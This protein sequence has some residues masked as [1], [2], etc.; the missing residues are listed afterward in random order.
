[1]PHF[2]DGAARDPRCPRPERDAVQAGLSFPVV[3]FPGEASNLV[4]HLG[5]GVS[6]LGRVGIRLKSGESFRTDCSMPRLTMAAAFAIR[7]M[8]PIMSWVT[9][10]PAMNW[11]VRA[12]IASRAD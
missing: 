6:P 4:F 3:D 11:I 10:S 1:L 2:Q 12:A 7:A 5:D 8:L 9:W